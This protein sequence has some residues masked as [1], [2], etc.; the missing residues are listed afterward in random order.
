MLRILVVSDT[1]VG[2]DLPARVRTGRRV[3]GHDFVAGLRRALQPAIA[4]EVDLV[5]HAGDV[6]DAPDPPAPV[7]ESAYGLLRDT[8][9]VVPVFVVP[10]NHERS[11]LPCPLLTMHP[12][13]RVFDRPRSF[14]LDV[15]GTTLALGGFPYAREV[16]RAFA[17]LV[18]DTQIVHT[19]ADARLLIVHHCIEGAVVSLPD[20]GTYRFST[21]ADVIAARDIPSGVAAVLSGHIH[22]HQVLR[23][24]AA[25][26][27]YGGSVERTAF[28]EAGETKGFYILTVEPSPQGGRVA[29]L[30]FRPLPTRPMIRAS[31]DPL[32]DVRQQAKR[33]LSA[34]DPDAIV[35]LEL[36]GPPQSIPALA[37]A[38]LR[39][40]APP[41]MNVHVV[42]GDTEPRFARLSRARRRSS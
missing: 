30:D 11:R 27:V 5:V 32:G 38:T 33:V 13:L 19:R 24:L 18:G 41:T 36:P 9:D 29:D 42:W 1:H 31:I 8:A 4:G 39:A 22:R 34:A 23:D 12:Q 21:A 28:A 6:F 20:G 14:T 37:A 3:R 25:P 15:R 2:F 26:V 40:L 16:R 7:A 10:G 17:G 35:R